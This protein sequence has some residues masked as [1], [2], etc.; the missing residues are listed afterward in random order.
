MNKPLKVQSVRDL[1][2]QFTDNYKRMVGQDG[3]YSIPLNGKTLWFFGDTMIGSRAA[4]QSLW[5][6]DGKPVGPYDM[7]GKG[8]IDNM[9]N[10]TGALVSL[11][12]GRYG[13]HGYEYICDKSG[14]IKQ[15]VP[16]IE[17]EDRD[18]IRI[19]CLHGCVAN[20]KL[21][22]YYIKVHML[23]EGP[24]PVNFEP[25]GSGIACGSVIDW[26]FQRVKYG[27]DTIFWNKSQPA[28]GTVVLRRSGDEFLY[29][30]GVRRVENG[31]Q[32][33]YLSRVA[34]SA[35]EDLAAYQYL[36]STTPHWSGHV[37][38]AMCIFTGP[39]NEL[40]VSYNRYLGCYLAVHSMDISGL[41]VARTAPEPWGPWSEPINLMKIFVHR[42]KPLPYPPLVY[43]AK[44]HPEL[45][46]GKGKVLYITYIEFEEY[47]PH[48]LEVT[49]A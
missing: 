38:D 46:E 20:D 37:G 5:Y 26:E 29:V 32:S 9:L 14:T 8:L 27:N 40:S 2:P 18:W 39:P 49:L 23:E 7:S 11:S 47:F 45:A 13:I 4:D 12:S 31:I 41:V 22:L 33:C 42:T 43:A 19:W 17:G 21:Y 35:I 44:E 25:V 30:Y 10:N 34:E 16:H 36:S 28:F 1:G 48:L 15:L 24:F 6:P 3:A